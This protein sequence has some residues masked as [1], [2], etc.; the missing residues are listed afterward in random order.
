[1]GNDV[2]G[3]TLRGVPQGDPA[4]TTIP[5]EIP[6]TSAA[7]LALSSAVEMMIVTRKITTPAQ[8]AIRSRRFSGLA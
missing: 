7:V 3:D 1:M 2:A 8:T 6:S 4:T 5:C